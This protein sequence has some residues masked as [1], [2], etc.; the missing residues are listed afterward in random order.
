[1]ATCKFYM[2]DNKL[3]TISG[4]DAGS[5]MVNDNYANIKIAGVTY[6]RSPFDMTISKIDTNQTITMEIT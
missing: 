4:A 5:Y 2:R 3:T 1:M 6:R